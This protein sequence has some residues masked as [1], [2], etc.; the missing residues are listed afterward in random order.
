M[1]VRRS[2]DHWIFGS[3]IGV[4]EGTLVVARALRRRDPQSNIFWA[5]SSDAEAQ[6]ASAEGF[7]PVWRDRW[8]GFR[9]TLRARHIVVTHSIGDV[10]EF[11][12]AGAT[13]V[14]L[15]HGAPLK[16]LHHHMSAMTDG[17]G[18]VKSILRRV[19]RLWS[20]RVTFYVAGSVTVAEW[21]REANQVAPGRVLAL[22]DPRDDVIWDA[23][24]DARCAQRTKRELRELL[25]LADAGGHGEPQEQLVLYAPTWRDGAL[26]PAIP[27][28]AEVASL[29]AFLESRNARLIVRSHPMG[30]GAW[31]EALGGAQRVHA[32]PADLAPDITPLLPGFDALITDYSS[33]AIDFAP[34]NRPIVW[35]APDVREYVAT[36]GLYEPL[37]LT[38]AG[39][40]DHTW[41]E[42]ESRLDRVLEG[43]SARRAAVQHSRALATRFHARPQGGAADRVLDEIQRLA[44]PEGD[45]VERGVFFESFEGRQAS[46]N[47]QAIDAEIA[48]RYPLLTRYWSV[49]SE[50]VATPPGAIPLLVGGADWFAARRRAR[51]LVVNDWLRYSFRPSRRQTVLQTW[52]GTM[53]KHLALTRPRTGLQTRIA[54]RRESRRWS[55]LLSQNSHS[56]AQFRCSYAFRG[57][58]LELG[59]PRDDRLARAVVDR[60]QGSDGREAPE[61]IPFVQAAA[62]RVLGVPEHVRVLAYVPTWREAARGAASGL[63][64]ILDVRATIAELDQPDDPWVILVRGHT[65]THHFGQYGVLEPR[66]IDVSTHPDIADVILAADMLVTDYSSVM[67]DAAVAQVPLAFFVPDLASYRDRERGFTFDFE[68]RAPGPLLS[69]RAEVIEKAR[70]LDAP[71]GWCTEWANAYADWRRDFVPHEDG[72]AALRVVDALVAKGALPEASGSA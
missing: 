45:R 31:N 67:F 55:L 42:V 66:V 16:R 28:E 13:I 24:A 27:G 49:T 52:H 63:V 48:R 9:A 8:E 39:H 71:G 57:E 47:P 11:G 60:A 25:G 20:S 70:T 46:C 37:E 72:S 22:G 36:R 64:D 21:L 12:V 53:L 6:R 58:I 59:Y 61:R 19:Y 1:F 69:T 51:L 15:G 17:A 50:R 26:D 5:I 23:A 38:A 30:S 56:T 54:V 32:L 62:K 29:V 14:H 35:F 10:N 2:P 33:I 4:G 68:S 43:G 41:S 65:R 34:L 3:P 18:F 40:I 44:R 7:T